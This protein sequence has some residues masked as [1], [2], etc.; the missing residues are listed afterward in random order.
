MTK[1]IAYVTFQRLD[2]W[3]WV[4]RL[5]SNLLLHC[6]AI[7]KS[8]KKLDLTTVYWTRVLTFNFFIV[9]YWTKLGHFFPFLW[10][11]RFLCLLKVF[12]IICRNFH[13]TS[14]KKSGDHNI[15]KSPTCL[16]N[17]LFMCKIYAFYAHMWAGGGNILCLDC[18]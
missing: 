17:R 7:S 18:M 9:V 1:Q 2:I 5:S 16:G 12:L 3:F 10:L 13:K 11:W 6:L 14:M 15:H 8:C 4:R